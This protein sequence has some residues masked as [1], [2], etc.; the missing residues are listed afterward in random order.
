MSNISLFYGLGLHLGKDCGILSRDKSVL[1]FYIDYL[2]Q[3]LL[4][5]RKRIDLILSRKI[6][7]A[8]KFYCFLN[9]LE[10]YEFLNSLIFFLVQ[11]KWI[12]IDIFKRLYCIEMLCKK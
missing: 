1:I 4:E 2:Y 11:H 9:F 6:L 8:M 10:K 3:Q 12:V 7:D 5:N